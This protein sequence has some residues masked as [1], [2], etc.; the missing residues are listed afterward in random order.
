[1]PYSP[2]EPG[3]PFGIA[4]ATSTEHPYSPYNLI[5]KRLLSFNVTSLVKQDD[6]RL[7]ICGLPIRFAMLGRQDRPQIARPF[8]RKRPAALDVLRNADER[9]VAGRG[10]AIHPDDV[11]AHTVVNRHAIPLYVPACLPSLGALYGGWRYR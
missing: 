2:E 8:E 11:T 9:L 3:Q 7:S 4:N 10:T 5:A 6:S 1:M